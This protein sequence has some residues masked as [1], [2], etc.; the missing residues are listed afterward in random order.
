M[1]VLVLLNAAAGTLA[2]SKDGDEAGRIARRFRENRMEVDVRAVDGS[3]MIEV[4]REARDAGE[5]DLILAGGG[6]GTVNTIAS[7]LVGGDVAFG[8]LPLGT[9]NHL[10]KELTIPLELDQAIDALSA[11]KTIDFDVG[12]VNEQIFL[13]FSAVGL[14]SDMVKHRD[15]Q[16][17][18]LGRAK[19]LA[20]IVAFFKMFTR[21]PLIRV[22]LTVEGTIIKRLTPVV[23]VALSE[24]QIRALGLEDFSCG[25]R[26]RL[27]I[28]LAAKTNRRGWAWM[29][30]KGLFGRL[31]PRKD[32]EVVTAPSAELAMRRRHVRV[33][34]DGEVIDMRTPLRFEV[35]KNGLKLRV[36][37]TYAPAS[38]AAESGS[39]LS[40]PIPAR[41]GTSAPSLSRG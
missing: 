33:G 1:R 30:I 32:F 14:Y 39:S 28:F 27:N 21:W 35:V 8:V 41:E 3:Q 2:S 13:L 10:A 5:Y 11:G 7:Q 20:G 12:R 16:R 40:D 24:Y 26:D 18:V 34:V 22:R 38:G 31:K 23:F 17:R 9:F 4:T 29:M 37:A 36:P 19:W 6:D 15:A 25:C